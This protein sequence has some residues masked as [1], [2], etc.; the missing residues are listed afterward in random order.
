[1][2]PTG[3]TVHSYYIVGHAGTMTNGVLI[4]SGEFQQ[5]S[6]WKPLAVTVGGLLVGLL[7][8]VVFVAGFAWLEERSLWILGLA[9]FFG[10]VTM[11]TAGMAVYKTQVE[12]CRHSTFRHYYST[13]Y[14]KLNEEDTEQE[15]ESSGVGR[16]LGRPGPSMAPPCTII[17]ESA[18]GWR[19]EAPQ[20]Q[21]LHAC[22]T[23]VYI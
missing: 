17:L 7:G 10:G 12:Y 8:T 21:C 16:K 23:A 9:L 22:G 11:I 3:R 20:S 19:G 6:F 18:A 2:T 5:P 4:L 1:M 13:G 15:K 14:G